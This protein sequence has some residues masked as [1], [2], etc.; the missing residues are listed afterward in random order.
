[1][2]NGHLRRR[3]DHVPAVGVEAAS[4][5]GGTWGGRGD[6]LLLETLVGD[7]H[8]LDMCIR[9]PRNVAELPP[10]LFRTRDRFQVR[11]N[12]PPFDCDDERRNS[13]RAL[14]VVL[15]GLAAGEGF[16]ECRTSKTI[17][18]L[19]AQTRRVLR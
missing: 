10:S 11:A 9:Q 13:P 18:L 16:G 5:L 2:G 6:S 15:K 1:M 4:L 19:R 8:L 14:R 17:A 12:R 3:Q 7:R